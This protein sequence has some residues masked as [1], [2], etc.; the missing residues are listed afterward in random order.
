MSH[1]SPLTDLLRPR[2]GALVPYGPEG[3]DVM[4]ADAFGPLELEYA[5]V[6]TR[7]ALLDRPDRG[8][9]EVRGED[10]IAFLNNM[11]T[12]ELAKLRPDEVAESFWLNRKGRIESDLRLFHL[13]DRMLVDVDVHA[14]AKTVESLAEFVFAEDAELSDATQQWHLLELAGPRSLEL[15]GILLDAPAPEPGFASRIGSPWGE[16]IV[17]RTDELGVPVLGFR[18][19]PDQA[20]ALHAAMLD[21]GRPAGLDRIGQEQGALTDDGSPASR[22]RLRECGWHALNI[23]R[24]EAGRPRFM[25]DF[26]PTNLPAETGVLHERVSFTKGCYLGQEVVAR[27][28]A[29]GHPKQILVAIR[30]EPRIVA[31]GTEDFLQPQTGS[32][33]TR[34]GEPDSI[35]GA[36]TSATLSPSLGR[37]PICLAQVKWGSHEPGTRLE[38]DAEGVRI[39]GEVQP[40]LRF[41]G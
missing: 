17:D 7:A 5:A 4:L 35:V 33:V 15:C 23:A 11:V 36:V 19:A 37:V 40:V 38:V 21:A 41:V 3:T 25:L 16:L 32:V 6:R 2:V 28:H 24:I 29:L 30:C 12:Q 18:V 39:V 20:G 22:I 1:P 14:A 10:R 13:P 26:G 31:G 34:E 8:T 27:M 9:I